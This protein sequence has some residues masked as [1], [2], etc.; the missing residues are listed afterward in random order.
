M[1]AQWPLEVCVSAGYIF[2]GTEPD[3]P[4]AG[5]DEEGAKDLKPRSPA[6]TGRSFWWRFPNFCVFTHVILNRRRC[7]VA[8]SSALGASQFKSHSSYLLLLL[9]LEEIE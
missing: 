2:L 9:S 5:E 6:S 3:K 4:S 7:H 8:S 1:I